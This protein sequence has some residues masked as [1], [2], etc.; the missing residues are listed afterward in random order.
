MDANSLAAVVHGA[1][2][3]ELAWHDG[4]LEIRMDVG[5]LE[6]S[7]RFARGEGEVLFQD[8]QF[9]GGG[10]GCQ[11]AAV[12]KTNVGYSSVAMR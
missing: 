3:F 2:G 10:D 9:S 4:L 12:E 5:S 11:T 8:D 6:V 1:D 7:I